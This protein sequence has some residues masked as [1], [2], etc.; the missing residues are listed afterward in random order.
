MI[1]LVSTSHLA[2]ALICVI[3][4]FNTDCEHQVT[5]VVYLL[6]PEVYP[7]PGIAAQSKLQHTYTHSKM[8][9]Y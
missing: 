1:V 4:I 9:W 5:Y 3:D 6:Y 7:L 2:D 8:S